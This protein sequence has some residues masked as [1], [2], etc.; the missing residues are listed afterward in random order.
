MSGDCV[1]AKWV[2]C[3]MGL[4]VCG[5]GLGERGKDWGGVAKE[6]VVV[7]GL[8]LATAHRARKSKAECF[9]NLTAFSGVLLKV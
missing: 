3:L 2:V 5:Q 9:K 7:G 6:W 4:G 1:K 8:Q